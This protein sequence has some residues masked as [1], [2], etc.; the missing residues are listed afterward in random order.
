MLNLNGDCLREAKVISQW[1]GYTI[2]S[3]IGY[4]TPGCLGTYCGLERDMPT[5]TYELEKG[6]ALSEIQRRHVPA[7]LEALKVSENT[8]QKHL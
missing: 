8:R 7:I 1:T 2:N 6:M 4:P 5:L 3:D